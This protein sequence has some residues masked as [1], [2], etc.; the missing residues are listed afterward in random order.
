[1]RSPYRM[2]LQRCAC[3]CVSKEPASMAE[4]G[5]YSCEGGSERQRNQ[6]DY[7]VLNPT[8]RLLLKEAINKR[9]ISPPLLSVPLSGLEFSLRVTR[10]AD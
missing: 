2:K 7:H 9:A 8:N 10:D 5:V 4:L 3:V 6:T 1:M